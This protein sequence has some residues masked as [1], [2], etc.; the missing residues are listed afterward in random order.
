[1]VRMFLSETGMPKKRID[2]P[3]VE[4]RDFRTAAEIALAIEKI[5]RESR[6]LSNSIFLRRY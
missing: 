5:R 2:P 3:A 4:S 6:S 1:M